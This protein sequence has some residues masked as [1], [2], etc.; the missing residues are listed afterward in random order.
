MQFVRLFTLEHISTERMLNFLQPKDTSGMIDPKPWYPIISPPIENAPDHTPHPTSLLNYLPNGITHIS[1]LKGSNVLLV[2]AK[3][4]DALDKMGLWVKLLDRE[5]RSVELEV[6]VVELDGENSSQTAQVKYPKAMLDKRIEMK[7]ARLLHSSNVV[8]EDG[9]GD[10]V[11]L[12]GCNFPLIG[13]HIMQVRWSPPDNI[14]LQTVPIY[15]NAQLGDPVDAERAHTLAFTGSI[16]SQA[17]ISP[18]MSTSWRNPDSEIPQQIVGNTIY[19]LKDGKTLILDGG[20]TEAG[21][22]FLISITA[23]MLPKKAVEQSNIDTQSTIRYIE[24]HSL[25]PLFFNNLT[26]TLQTLNVKEIDGLD[27]V[28]AIMSFHALLAKGSAKALNELE[29][30]IA[31]IDKPELHAIVEGLLAEVDIPTAKELGC[32]QADD[33]HWQLPAPGAQRD[34]YLRMN[35]LIANGVIKVVSNS[36]LLVQLPDKAAISMQA[37]LADRNERNAPNM[38]TPDTLHRYG[39]SVVC[40]LLTAE[41]D[42]PLSLAPFADLRDWKDAGVKFPITLQFKDKQTLLAGIWANQD[43]K[44]DTVLLFFVTAQKAIIDTQPE[45]IE[46][47]PPIWE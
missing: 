40:G 10:L 7:Q 24:L 12:S 47:L 3:S 15:R 32:V 22:K 25:D 9:E 43:P 21:N 29:T 5:T 16:T 36:R 44:A 41:G 39:F 20:A 42:I 35:N 6:Q 1:L 34:M 46:A 27:S 31:E 37:P 28:A 13:L 30:R 38:N 17:Y 45:G 23:R 8:I 14:S 33:G 26:E 19:Q 2:T 18:S 11:D 4:V